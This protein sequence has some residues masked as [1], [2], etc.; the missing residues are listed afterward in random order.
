MTKDE[1]LRA[2]L[3]AQ[4][5]RTHCQGIEVSRIAERFGISED[6]ARGYIVQRWYEDKMEGEEWT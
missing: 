5:Y 1:T 6:E 2:K 3:P 4:V